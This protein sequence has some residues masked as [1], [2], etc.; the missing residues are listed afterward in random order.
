MI[1]AFLS[2]FDGTL[3]SKDI[4][5]VVC[6]IVGKEEESKTINEEFQAGIRKGINESIIP[7]INF[8]KGVTH[9]QIKQELDKNNFLIHGAQELFSFL[10]EKN[11]QTILH[12]GNI[13]PVL[14]YYQNILGIDYVVG[15]KPNMDGEIIVNITEAEFPA[16]RQF[17]LVW[18]KE[19]LNKLNIKPEETVAIGDS[20]ADKAIFEFAGKS[21]A[22]NP[23]NGI[24]QYAD[25]VVKNDLTEV[26]PIIEQL[27]S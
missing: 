24:E 22:I 15:T 7:R 11:I 18:I 12:S 17:K 2:D 26:I 6:G 20:P 3:V 4:L 14:N 8:L 27:S 25:Y 5:D 16:D 10:K 9:T 1:K 19:L 13:L 21:I 23:K